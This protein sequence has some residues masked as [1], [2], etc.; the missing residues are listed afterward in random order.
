MV[1]P[2]RSTRKG[3]GQHSSVD[4]PVNLTGNPPLQDSTAQN[5]K[6][7][8]KPTKKRSITAMTKEQEND[9]TKVPPT[10]PEQTKKR[11]KSDKVKEAEEDVQ[12]TKKTRVGKAKNKKGVTTVEYQIGL[13]EV[14]K[15]QAKAAAAEA[16]LKLADQAIKD[17]NKQLQI[18]KGQL[19]LS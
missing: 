9:L 16:T 6:K 3:K 12:G 13:A 4:V 18:F 19:H 8:A 14:E 5:K 15:I 17:L 11:G 7:T 1:S 2:R 10:E